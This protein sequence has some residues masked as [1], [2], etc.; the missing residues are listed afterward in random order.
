MKLSGILIRAGEKIICPKCLS[1]LYRVT[2]DLHYGEMVKSAYFESIETK[3]HPKERSAA[4]SK[5]CKIP[6]MT[7]G[8]LFTSRGWIPYI[9]SLYRVSPPKIEST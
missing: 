6:W 1:E 3:E 4:I 5:C 9:P 7:E 2:Q 8:S